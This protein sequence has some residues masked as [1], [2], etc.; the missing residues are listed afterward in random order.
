MSTKCQDYNNTFLN[1]KTDFQQVWLIIFKK[2]FLFSSNNFLISY[3]KIVQY[4]L[5]HIKSPR[6]NFLC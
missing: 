2:I 6:F 3:H 5:A 1:V 4:D